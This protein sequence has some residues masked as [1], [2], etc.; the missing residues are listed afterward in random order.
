MVVKSCGTTPNDNE[1]DSENREPRKNGLP[2]AAGLGLSFRATTASTRPTGGES[3]IRGGRWVPEGI[4]G[5]SRPSRSGLLRA[6][7][8]GASS[9]GP[10]PGRRL[11]SP[12]LGG[13][14]EMETL[15]K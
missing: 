13:R 7:D 5:W 3:G 9:T 2:H 11:S 12:G 1:F 10:V 15:A 6:G 14:G 4:D 8:R